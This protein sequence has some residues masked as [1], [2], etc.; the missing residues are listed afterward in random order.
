MMKKR[1]VKYY[2]TRYAHLHY[3]FY[4]AFQTKRVPNAEKGTSLFLDGKNKNIFFEKVIG[5]FASLNFTV[6]I[7]R[8][9]KLKSQH[10]TLSVNGTRRRD[11]SAA[12]QSSTK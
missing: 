2:K 6:T 4:H 5:K 7:F 10:I 12:C 8:S 1:Y 11:Q 3:G 9:P